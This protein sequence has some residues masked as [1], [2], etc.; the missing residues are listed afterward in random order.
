MSSWAKRDVAA[1]GEDRVAGWLNRVPGYTGYRRKES[2]RD[3]DKRVRDELAG[4]Y[5]QYT[6]RLTAVQGELARARR[7]TEIGAIERLERALRLFTDRLRVATY[8]YGGL[9]SERPID[10][11]ALDQLGAFD[12]ALGDGL[13]QMRA[14]VEALEGAA[15]GGGDLAEPARQLQGTIDGLNRRFDLRGQ[16]VETGRA[17]EGP[18][19]ADLF[20]P[21]GREQ[22]HVAGELHFGDAVTVGGADYLVQGRMEFHAGDDAWRQYLLRD[23]DAERWLHVPPVAS[24]PMA[25]LERLAEPPGEGAQLSVGGASYTQQAAGEATA[26]VVGEGGKQAD[27]TVR[28]R[29]YGGDAG[30]LLFVYDWGGGERQALAGRALDP[31]EVTVYAR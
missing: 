9:F 2:R 17:Q 28:Y 21:P 26:E 24:A 29:R 22:A 7:V 25:L 4:Q 18:A 14:G 20:A 12:R 8:G 23:V 19:V 6:Q 15:R 30:A 3:E 1:G 5:G 31:L 27:R 13:D 10:E 16:V 11:R